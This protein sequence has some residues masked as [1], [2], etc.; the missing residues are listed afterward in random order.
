[1]SWKHAAAAT[2]CVATTSPD[3]QA[4]GRLVVL[5]LLVGVLLALSIALVIA[6]RWELPHV[7]TLPIPVVVI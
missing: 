5:L 3:G 4:Y 2:V 6:W 7:P 1:M